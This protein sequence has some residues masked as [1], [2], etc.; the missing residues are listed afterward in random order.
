[1]TVE[2]WNTSIHTLHRFQEQQKLVWVFQGV[3][4]DEISETNFTY[5]LTNFT[6]SRAQKRDYEA[7]IELRNWWTKNN[8]SEIL[9]LNLVI[10][11]DQWVLYI[12]GKVSKHNV[13]KL[14][15]GN[16]RETRKPSEDSERVTVHRALAI[17]RVVGPFYSY[18]PISSWECCFHFLITF[19]LP[20]LPDLHWNVSFI[21]IAPHIIMAWDWKI[22]W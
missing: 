12:D 15:S 11:F 7:H 22:S 4:F 19:I 9:F 14:G 21:M 5:F 20:M 10:R 18:E 1:M 8:K 13:G 17:D 6:F 2:Y 16:P 3:T